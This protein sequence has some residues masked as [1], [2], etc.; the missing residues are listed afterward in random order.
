MINTLILNVIARR[1]SFLHHQYMPKGGTIKNKL[2]KIF[3]G[4]K[5]AWDSFFKPGLIMATPLVSTAVAAKTKNPQSAQ[6]TNKIS[7]SITGGEI[8]SQTDTHGRCLR[9]KVM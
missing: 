7:K 4:T 9:L 6:I 5:K 8:L 2:Q 3:R 1:Q